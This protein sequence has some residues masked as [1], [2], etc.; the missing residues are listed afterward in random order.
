MNAIIT[1]RKTAT[2]VV[3]D[4]PFRSTGGV[5]CLISSTTTR[6]LAGMPLVVCSAL[7]KSRNADVARSET[8]IALRAL[9]VVAAIVIS[10]RGGALE[11]FWLARTG[12]ARIAPCLTFQSRAM[13]RLT[14]SLWA[15]F[16]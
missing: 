16:E 15:R 7:R 13:I 5:A 2:G 6:F 8:S 14:A 3:F 11:L 12:C 1:A 10:G 4:R 9:F